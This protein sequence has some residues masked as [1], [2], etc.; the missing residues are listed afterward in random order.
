MKKCLW[1]LVGNNNNSFVVFVLTFSSQGKGKIILNTTDLR[2]VFIV[3]AVFFFFRKR[4]LIKR[5]KKKNK[6]E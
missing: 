2:C 6:N 1:S 5:K 3:V 4:M